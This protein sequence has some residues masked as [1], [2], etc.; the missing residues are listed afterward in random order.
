MTQKAIHTI[1]WDVVSTAPDTAWAGPDT[2][3]TAIWPGPMDHDECLRSAG[4][5]DFEDSDDAWDGEFERLGHRLVTW[6]K[7]FGEP[8][9]PRP[10]GARQA[11]VHVLSGK[12]G[13]SVLIRRI[14]APA[15]DDRERD[16]IVNFGSPPV[17]AIRTGG[18]HEIFWLA[19]RTGEAMDRE[20]LLEFLAEGRAVARTSLKWELLL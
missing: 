2:Q 1:H 12:P 15:Y 17:A 8:V 9:I 4:F 6:L 14:L 20:D 13:D 5:A 16:V 3:V 7:R 10:G 18:S 11:V 19:V